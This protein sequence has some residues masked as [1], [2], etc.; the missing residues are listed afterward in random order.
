[1]KT[2][3][4][5]TLIHFEDKSALGLSSEIWVNI[6][7]AMFLGEIIEYNADTW[8]KVTILS[9]RTLGQKI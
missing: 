3:S 5:E 1:V 9:T 8:N 2:D 7:E 6:E 4:N